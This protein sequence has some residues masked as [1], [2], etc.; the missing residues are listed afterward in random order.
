MYWVLRNRV[1]ASKGFLEIA[2]NKAFRWM[3]LW[4]DCG[5]QKAGGK[6]ERTVRKIKDKGAFRGRC[7]WKRS[8]RSHRASTTRPAVTACPAVAVQIRRL[9][10]A[11]YSQRRNRLMRLDWLELA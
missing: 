2:R 11:R 7:G 6:E 10:F 8:V 5:A 3:N 4:V 1:G 9:A